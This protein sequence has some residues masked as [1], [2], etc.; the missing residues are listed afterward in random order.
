MHI[1]FF[2]DI[3]LKYKILIRNFYTLV[4]KFTISDYGCH[5]LRPLKQLQHLYN[6]HFQGCYNIAFIDHI[7][8]SFLRQNNVQFKGKSIKKLLLEQK[9]KKMDSRTISGKNGISSKNKKG[10]KERKNREERKKF[11]FIERLGINN[12]L[13]VNDFTMDGTKD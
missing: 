11:N 5:M 1:L 2:N 6:Y 7:P 12:L 4:N 8:I 10:S 9:G 3:I 13:Q